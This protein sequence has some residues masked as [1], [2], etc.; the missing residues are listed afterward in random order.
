[1]P[2]VEKG[3]PLL[4][5]YHIGGSEVGDLAAHL[6]CAPCAVA[7]E[8]AQERGNPVYDS[9]SLTGVQVDVVVIPAEKKTTEI[10]GD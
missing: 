5:K 2:G 6:F 9:L 8:A 4:T 1:M 7:Q 10:G 3:V